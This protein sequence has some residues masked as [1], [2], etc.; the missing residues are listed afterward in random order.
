[1]NDFNLIIYNLFATNYL[2]EFHFYSIFIF[3]KINY[4]HGY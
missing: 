2:I 1:M 4:T 3:K